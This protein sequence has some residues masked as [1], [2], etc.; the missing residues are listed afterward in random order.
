VIQVKPVLRV[1]KVR[2]ALQ[3]QQVRKVLKVILVRL[4]L[5]VIQA[6]R[7][8]KVIL[9]RLE[10]LAHRVHKDL[11]VNL[12]PLSLMKILPLHSLNHYA[13]RRVFKVKK[14]IREIKVIPEILD[15][16]DLKGTKVI[17]EILETQVQLVLQVR[18]HLF[19]G[20]PHQKIL[21]RFG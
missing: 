6:K 3:A 20:I 5:K 12:V 8:R 2:L 1:L 4:V 10:P 9:D 14:V 19:M 21:Q 16:K 18:I 13:D 17:K 11:R 7:V 15:L